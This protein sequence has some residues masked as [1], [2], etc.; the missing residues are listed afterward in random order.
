MNDVHCAYNSFDYKK[1]HRLRTTANRTS[2]KVSPV[3][4]TDSNQVSPETVP[5]KVSVEETD[6]MYDK[7]S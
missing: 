1:N 5:K 3:S 6:N 4:E 7:T 2:N